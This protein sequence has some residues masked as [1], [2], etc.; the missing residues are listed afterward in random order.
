MSYAPERRDGTIA[1][2]KT[3]A[4]MVRGTRSKKEGPSAGR[5]GAERWST[6]Q[7]VD[8]M[9]AEVGSIPATMIEGACNDADAQPSLA[10][11]RSGKR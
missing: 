3:E 8:T 9:I 7:D 4:Q 6:E 10:C 1:E 2:R 11:D 5:L